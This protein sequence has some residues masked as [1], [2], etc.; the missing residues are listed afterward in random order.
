MEGLEFLNDH[1]LLMSSG[2][3]GSSYLDIIDIDQEP[4]L[5]KASVSLESK[6]FGEG[7]TYLPSKGEIL[8]LTYRQRKAFRFSKDLQQL[9]TLDIPREIREGWGMTHEE[10][11][12]LVSDGTDRVFYVDPST[13]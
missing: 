2:E 7:I 6:Y 1:E 10:E 9:E 3:Y 4:L 5:P 11:T 12:L 8:M 13:F